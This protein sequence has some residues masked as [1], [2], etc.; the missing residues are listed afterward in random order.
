MSSA[1]AADMLVFQVIQESQVVTYR[2][3]GRELQVDLNT[4][5]QLMQEFYE[6]NK[7]KCH[8]TFLIVTSR[9][10]KETS[11]IVAS[12]L[13]IRLVSDTKLSEPLEDF[14]EVDRHIYALSPRPLD[15]NSV[16]AMANVSAGSN[17]EMADLSAI[18]ASVTIIDNQ[19]GLRTDHAAAVVKPQKN[20]PVVKN[21]PKPIAVKKEPVVKKEAVAKDEKGEDVDMN[22]SQTPEPTKDTKKPKDAKSFFGRQIAT[23]AQSGVSK[24]HKAD[25]NSMEEDELPVSKRKTTT[26]TAN[27]S[28]STPKTKPKPSQALYSDDVAMHSADE[29]KPVILGPRVEDMFD[30]DSD[31]DFGT[32]AIKKSETTHTE[33]DSDPMALDS[34]LTTGSMTGADSDV[35]MTEPS[36]SSANI[37]NQSTHPSVKSESNQSKLNKVISNTV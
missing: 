6:A 30:D 24:K 7:A 13:S 9:N 20:A 10:S 17:R 1:Q 33:H 36:D 21:E 27:A 8:A 14:E 28:A 37:A 26:T 19:P 3:L 22:D 18:S 32:T 29:D 11:S 23:S 12:E 25:A 5:K 34:Q 15:D 4:A 35:D 16:L 2:K 31:D